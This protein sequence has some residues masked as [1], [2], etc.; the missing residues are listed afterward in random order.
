MP[1]AH[2]AHA[3]AQ[4]ILPATDTSRA[5]SPR[6]EERRARATAALL[7]GSDPFPQENGSDPS[8][9]LENQC[10]HDL[11]LPLPLLQKPAAGSAAAAAAG[12]PE[13]VP[14]ARL[15]PPPQRPITGLSR[16]VPPMTGSAPPARF[17]LVLL[18]ESPASLATL[19]QQSFRPAQAQPADAAHRARR[20]RALGD[21]RPHAVPGPHRD[22]QD[23]AE[24]P[25]RTE[26]RH[27]AALPSPG[28][29]RRAQR[30]GG[31]GRCAAGA[32]GDARRERYLLLQ[33]LRHRLHAAD[34]PVPQGP[35]RQG[36]EGLPHRRR[37][38]HLLRPGPG[39]P[40]RRRL[41]QLPLGQAGKQ[42]RRRKGRLRRPVRALE[43]GG[44]QRRLHGRRA[45]AGTGFHCHH[46]ALRWPAR[47]DRSRPELGHRQPHRTTAQ[48][49]HRRGRRHRQRSPGQPHRPA[50]A[51]RTGPPAGGHVRHAAAAARGDQRPARDG[52]PPRC[53]RTELSHRC[54][55]L[56]GRVRLDGAGNQRAGR[57]PRADP[58]RRA[59]RGAAVR[60]R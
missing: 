40:R 49:G 56:P 16:R 50:A 27:P 55:C 9:H 13:Y 48:A 5:R 39:R 41:R 33:R 58:A 60:G 38:A 57:Q 51:R 46:G 53:R 6:I 17:D 22:P 36:H 21:R 30:S 28:R 34:A 8:F 26:L 42:G 12:K 32:G 4:P 2:A 18:D 23:C 19:L 3:P 45:E 20:D 47:A 59:G 1:R 10:R 11:P 25:G 7:P 24:D 35:G 31:Q 14:T 43:L 15:N 44:Q 37:R 29:H 54:Q 52:P